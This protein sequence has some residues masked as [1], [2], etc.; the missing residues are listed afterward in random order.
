MAIRAGKI[1]SVPDDGNATKIQPSEIN[2]FTQS[3]P[4]QELDLWFD[5]Q[6]VPPAAGSSVTIKLYVG[7][8]WVPI[9]S[10][11]Y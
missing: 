10:A 11:S 9:V 7:G 8:A 5:V 6:G 3:V 1:S 4:P 2:P